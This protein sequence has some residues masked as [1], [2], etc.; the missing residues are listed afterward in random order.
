[1]NICLFTSSFLPNVGGMENVVHWLALEYRKL[2]HQ[3]VVLAKTPRKMKKA[4]EF[5][6]PVYYYKRSR[7]E[8]FFL[9]APRK[10]LRELHLQYDFDVIHAHQM[11]PTGYLAVRMAKK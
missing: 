8:V 5:P 10:M 7:S 11:Y 6:Y 4:P 1:M 2:G 9:Q 3:V